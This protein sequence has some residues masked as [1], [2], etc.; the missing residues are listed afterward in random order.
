[1][2]FN[3]T[4]DGVACVTSATCTGGGVCGCASASVPSTANGCN[5]ILLDLNVVPQAAVCTTTGCGGGFEGASGT[6][7]IDADMM[8]V[9][10][11][12]NASGLPST[13]EMRRDWL[14]LIKQ[15]LDGKM[16]ASSGP[17]LDVTA[18]T[19]GP[20]VT[21]GDTIDASGGTVNL[22]IEVQAAP[23]IPVD[24]VRI[25]KNGCVL[26]CYN[27]STIPAV[28][29]QPAANDQ[30]NTGVVRFNAT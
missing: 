3:G 25:I 6:R 13:K 26:A 9:D 20:T 28:S 18:D 29:A 24:E 4:N 30:T 19:G 22:N 8:E 17:I 1:Q 21:L 2:C 10:N 14:S 16:F 5:S 12:G 15:V 7:N 27:S 23:W 11:G